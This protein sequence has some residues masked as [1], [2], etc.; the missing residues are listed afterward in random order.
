MAFRLRHM[1]H[2]MTKNSG[3]RRKKF[4]RVFNFMLLSVLLPLCAKQSTEVSVKLLEQEKEKKVLKRAYH[5]LSG[6]NTIEFYYH[7][8]LL[9]YLKL[10]ANDDIVGDFISET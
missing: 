3:K 7:V 9:R 5:F 1:L 10:V 8:L 6:M 2:K 4:F